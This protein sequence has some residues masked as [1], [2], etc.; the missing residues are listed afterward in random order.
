MECPL[1]LGEN[2]MHRTMHDGAV[3][4]RKCGHE[5]TPR[6]YNREVENDYD[7]WLASPPEETVG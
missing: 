6:E 5:M 7:R 3:A 2:N 1:C 4:C